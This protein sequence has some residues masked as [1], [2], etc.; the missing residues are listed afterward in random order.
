MLKYREFFVEKLGDNLKI[1]E[2]NLESWKNDGYSE[3]VHRELIRIFH[4][5]KSNAAFVE[6]P[7]ISELAFFTEKMLA[8]YPA[9]GSPDDGLYPYVKEA[10]LHLKTAY[11]SMQA[12]DYGLEIAN[13][14]IG[15]LED[16]EKNGPGKR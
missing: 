7:A 9:G 1:I 12:K 6:L 8:A 14:L 5:I 2:A 15:R 3:T 10:Y 11:K 4:N 16:K 13:D